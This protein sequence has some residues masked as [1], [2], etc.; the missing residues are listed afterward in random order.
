MFK[1]LSLDSRDL[2]LHIKIVRLSRAQ[3]GLVMTLQKL[4]FNYFLDKLGCKFEVNWKSCVELNK[5][6]N[7]ASI[8]RL[9]KNL[10]KLKSV[11]CVAISIENKL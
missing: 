7:K 2:H 8:K 1:D 4:L 9:V 11:I 5:T 10:I 6:V 3:F